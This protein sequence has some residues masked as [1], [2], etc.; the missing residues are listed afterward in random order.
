MENILGGWN[1]MHTMTEPGDGA[2]ALQARDGVHC[3][4]AQPV[5]AVPTVSQR[6]EIC[7]VDATESTLRKQ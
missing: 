4:G 7:R 5:R 6:G 1:S 2:R 3:S